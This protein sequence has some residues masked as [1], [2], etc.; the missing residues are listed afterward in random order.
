[1]EFE[2]YV[3]AR[4]PA[5]LRLAYALTGDRHDAEDLV[6]AVLVDVLER[7]DRVSGADRPEAYVHRAVVNRHLSWRRRRSSSDVLL[8]VVPE[9]RGGAVGDHGEGVVARDELW[10]AVRS[11]PPRARTVLV[12]RYVGDLDDAAIAD[13]MDVTPST[14]PAPA[15]PAPTSLPPYVTTADGGAARRTATVEPTRSEDR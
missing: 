15:S 2:E 14:V 13:A 12:L 10:R 9:P 7:W 6:Q 5:L 4:G 11:L 1:M 8:S 3:A